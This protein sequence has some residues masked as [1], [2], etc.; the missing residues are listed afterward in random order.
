MYMWNWNWNQ[1][2]F[3][4]KQGLELEIWVLSSM[5]SIKIGSDFYN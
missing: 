4:K 2:I 5:N 3:I 1:N